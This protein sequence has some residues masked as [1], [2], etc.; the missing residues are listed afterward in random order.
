MGKRHVLAIKT[1]LFSILIEYQNSISNEDWD[2]ILAFFILN[3]ITLI[4]IFYYRN[5]ISHDQ[6]KLN[7]NYQQGGII[8]QVN[9]PFNQ[10]IGNNI[11][12][13]NPRQNDQH[14]PTF[15]RNNPGLQ[16]NVN[17][18]QTDHQVLHQ[19][20]NGNQQFLQ[21]S[22]PQNNNNFNH[23]NAAQPTSADNQLPLNTAILKQNA[24][25]MT[26]DMNLY[27]NQ[28]HPNRV[29]VQKAPSF[30]GNGNLMRQGKCRSP[31]IKLLS[32]FQP[33]IIL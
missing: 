2:F 28:Q 30:S 17:C 32:F 25:Q 9:Q 23:Y 33:D 19:H 14:D 31:E 3:G 7:Q 27:T 18:V 5:F 1:M 13:S 20:Q 21:N 15:D 8:S 11:H 10:Q 4:T 24:P 6:Q 26:S 22:N 12:E 16:N 29:K